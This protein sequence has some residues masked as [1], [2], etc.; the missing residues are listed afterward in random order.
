MFVCYATSVL[1]VVLLNMSFNLLSPDESLAAYT[2]LVLKFF[3]VTTFMLFKVLLHFSAEVVAIVQTNTWP[4][5]VLACAT[6]SPFHL[7]S[8][9]HPFLAQIHIF[10]V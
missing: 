9:S 5:C 3:C 10:I 7:K 8:L 1:G 4:E 6:R 2:A